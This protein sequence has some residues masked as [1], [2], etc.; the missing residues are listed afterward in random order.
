MARLCIIRCRKNII[1]NSTTDM[2]LNL[3]C[4]SFRRPLKDSALIFQSL[5]TGGGRLCTCFFSDD[6]LSSRRP[7][8][9]G[10]QCQILGNRNIGGPKTTAEQIYGDR[11]SVPSH[12]NRIKRTENQHNIVVILEQASKQA[13]RRNQQT[14]ASKRNERNEPLAVAII[15][16][17][18][19][20]ALTHATNRNEANRIAGT[21]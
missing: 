15:A 3:I 21:D 2:P 18:V 16:S 10:A 19:R 6:Y 13:T 5:C 17:I 1:Y 11:D 14:T 9:H 12:N 4:D 8:Q 20:Y 7:R